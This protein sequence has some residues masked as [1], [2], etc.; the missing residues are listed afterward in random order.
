MVLTIYKPSVREIDFTID[1]AQ[2]SYILVEKG[3]AEEVEGNLP[4]N[5]IITSKMI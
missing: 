1:K 4:P 3:S 2:N 5:F